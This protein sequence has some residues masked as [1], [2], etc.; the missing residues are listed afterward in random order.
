MLFHASLGTHCPNKRHLQ[1]IHMYSMPQLH[2]THVE[3]LT[4]WAAP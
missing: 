3:S 2:I 4:R 1:P